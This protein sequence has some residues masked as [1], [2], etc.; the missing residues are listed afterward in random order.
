MSRDLN[1]ALL[2][3][4]LDEGA[5]T[6]AVGPYEFSSEVVANV[7]RRLRTGTGEGK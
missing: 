6:H 5:V 4:T 2:Q 3:K 7:K 1:A